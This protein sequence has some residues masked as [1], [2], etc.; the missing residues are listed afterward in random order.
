VKAGTFNLLSTTVVQ[1]K[2]LERATEAAN[3]KRP[4]YGQALVA[5]RQGS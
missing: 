4:C 3:A 2:R 5:S 1:M